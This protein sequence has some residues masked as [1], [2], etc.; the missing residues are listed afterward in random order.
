MDFASDAVVVVTRTV[1][2][3]FEAMGEGERCHMA[4]KL[5]KEGYKAVKQT[6]HDAEEVREW[7]ILEDACEFWKA[8]AIDRGYQE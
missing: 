4:N 5:F 2:E 6:Q 7:I 3:I 8:E 1:G